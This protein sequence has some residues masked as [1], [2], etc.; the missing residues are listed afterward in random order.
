VKVPAII[1]DVRD[2]LQWIRAKGPRVARLDPQRVVVSGGSAGGYL[3]MMTGICVKPKPTALVAY[4]GYGDIDGSWYTKPSPH[5]CTA[6]PIIRKEE[7][8]HAVGRGVLTHV[9]S[10]TPY[11]KERGRY[12][13]YL[14]QN[15]LWTEEVSGFDVETQKKEL[16]AYCP[17]RNI[18]PAYPP[19]LMIHGTEDTD[20]PYAK[21]ADMAREL[22]RHNVPHEFV[23]VPAAGHGLV[24]GERK[25][26][27][28][29]RARALAFIRRHLGAVK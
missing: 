20:V 21:S 15:G 6:V 5:Y 22:A 18:S 1:E 25:L 3:T 11:R 8:E 10:R 9:D 7:V 26:V 16:T 23:T 13:L 29:A 19:I 27:T 17:V 14:R 24:R 4:W 28:E 12:Y 2:A